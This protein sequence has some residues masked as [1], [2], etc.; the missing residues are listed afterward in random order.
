MDAKKIECY[1]DV[2]SP[3]SFYS[4]DY[5]QKNRAALEAQ[6]VEFEFIPV[7]LGGINVGSGNKPPWE[8]PAK[9][10]YSKFDTKR[11]QQYFG[12][13]FTV[14]DF[15]PILSLLPQRALTYIKRNFSKGQFESTFQAFFNAMWNNHIDIS[16][17]ENLISVLSRSSLFTESQIK[18]ILAGASNPAIKQELT[19]TTAK[20]VKELGAFGCPWFWV[21]AGNGKSE[22]FFGSD[23]WAYMW[24]FLG[25]EFE[26][27]RLVGPGEGGKREK[28]KL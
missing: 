13:D 1:I 18:D 14:P 7:F 20:A 26:D 3:Y 25:L 24:R 6:N 28:G 16:N 22:P 17:P 5:L 12:H 27:L 21:S 2:V 11:A 4:F 9:A 23:R 8:L 19:G 15:F 10:A